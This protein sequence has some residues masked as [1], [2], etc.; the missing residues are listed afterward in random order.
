MASE[1]TTQAR[2]ENA[3]EQSTGTATIQLEPLQNAETES[4]TQLKD[5][6]AIT[7]PDPDPA[8]NGIKIDV[9]VQP[10]DASTAADTKNDPDQ[11]ASTEK[12]EQDPAKESEESTEKS[13]EE[14]AEESGEQPAKSA[15]E[16]APAESEPKTSNILYV[17]KFLISDKDGDLRFNSEQA[18]QDRPTVAPNTKDRGLPNH[19]ASVLEEH[20]EFSCKD[21]LS[22]SDADSAPPLRDRVDHE[23]LPVI[24]ILSPFVLNALKALITFPSGP[25]RLERREWNASDIKDSLETGRFVYPFRD[26]YHIQQRLRQYREDVK[27][28]HDET[29]SETCGQHLDILLEYLDDQATS[30]IL[31]DIPRMLGHAS[32]KITLRTLWYLFKPGSDVYV[33]EDGKLN[34]YVVESSRYSSAFSWDSDDGSLAPYR[35]YVWNMNFDGRHLKRSV[36]EISIEGFAGQREIHSLLV[37]PVEYQ[38]DK[39]DKALRQKLIDRGKRFVDMVK[40][41]SLLEYTGPSKMNGIRDYHKARAVVDH[42]SQPWTLDNVKDSKEVFNPVASVHGVELNEYTRIP[43]CPCQ[44]CDEKEAQQEDMG[45]LRRKFDDYDEINLQETAVLTDHQYMLCPT[46][47]YGAILKDNIWEIFEVDRLEQPTIQTDLIDMLVMKADE[48]KQILKAIFE[49]YGGSHTQTQA[50]SS[51]F[52]RGKRKAQTVLLHGPPGTGKTFT[53]ESL[54]EYAS[55]PI[56]RIT[57]ADLGHGTDVEK[58]LTGYFRTTKRWNAIVLL[59]HTDDLLEASSCSSSKYSGFLRALDS[60]TGILILT[61]TRVTQFDRA[62]MS[63]INVRIGYDPLDEDMRQR[64]WENH[65]TQLTR[66]EDQNQATKKHGSR[67][68]RIRVSDTAREFVRNSAAL[69]VLNWNGHEIRNAFQTALAL[70]CSQAKAKRDPKE[71]EDADRVLD[72][73]G[74]HLRQVVSMSQNFKNYLDRENEWMDYIYL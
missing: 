29:Y 59:E 73:T 11:T 9:P 35:V 53:A 46:H 1:L 5:A 61:S 20:R 68:I 74:E 16:E 51:D 49:L 39:D 40:R 6:T 31:K 45:L 44:T 55:L 62:I 10:N 47:V 58:N 65:F 48:N 67:K 56:L 26:L 4:G 64:I 8:S 28:S 36:K 32:P 66:N 43:K 72:L 27:E 54:A 63:R 19:T 41:P 7:D 71:N 38:D 3:E 2:M 12:P 33:R 42:G 21:S 13:G 50:F 18:F 52:V 22:G 34:A 57:A 69:Q 14:A 30:S 17:A 25:D 70:A 15:D 24:R 37:F 60:Y 23:G